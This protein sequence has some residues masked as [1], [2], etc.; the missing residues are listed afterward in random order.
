MHVLVTGATG[1]IGRQASL[2]CSGPGTPSP[3]VARSDAAA[4]TGVEVF[5]QESFSFLYADGGAGWLDEADP[6]VRAGG[7]GVVLRMARLVSSLH[8]HDAGTAVAAALGGMTGL[9]TVSRRV[10][11]RR[12]HQAADWRPR[13]HNVQAGWPTVAAPAGGDRRQ[14]V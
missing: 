12:F 5:V 3:G 10:S 6:F 7:R 4:A 13:Y 8:V 2:A 14:V 9:L 11:N 1:V